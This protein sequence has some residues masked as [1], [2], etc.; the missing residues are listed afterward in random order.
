MAEQEIRVT[1]SE[2]HAD[3][4]PVVVAQVESQEGVTPEWEDD[5]DAKACKGCEKKF[6]MTRRRHHC[7]YVG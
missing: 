5:K 1:D 2:E 6:K 4:E 7:R 3:G